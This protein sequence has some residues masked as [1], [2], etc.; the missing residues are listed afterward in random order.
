MRSFLPAAGLAFLLVCASACRPARHEANAGKGDDPRVAV[1]RTAVASSTLVRP[2][3]PTAPAAP[4]APDEGE[5]PFAPMVRGSWREA[6]RSRTYTVT[7]DGSRF[8][9]V[10]F[11]KDR[12]IGRYE[13][14]LRGRQVDAAYV[15]DMKGPVE[16]RAALELSNDGSHLAGAFTLKEQFTPIEWIRTATE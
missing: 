8:V 15:S 9:A 12:E 7:G 14:W 10:E 5:S 6:K 1:S 3:T 16:G 4:E 2:V 13:G 11:Q